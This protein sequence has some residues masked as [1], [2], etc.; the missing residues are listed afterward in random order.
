MRVQNIK[1]FFYSPSVFI[2]AFRKIELTRQLE[3][4]EGYIKKFNV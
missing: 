2:S 4:N 3:Y 1:S